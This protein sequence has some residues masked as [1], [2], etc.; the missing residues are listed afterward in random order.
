[1]FAVRK[2]DGNWNE[3][4]SWRVREGWKLGKR[5]KEE[6]GRGKDREARWNTFSSTSFVL[7]RYKGKGGGE[8]EGWEI[9]AF[10][11]CFPNRV[12]EILLA[13]WRLARKFQRFL[14]HPSSTPGFRQIIAE[15]ERNKLGG[16]A[17]R[18][19]I[20]S[21]PSSVPRFSLFYFSREFQLEIILSFFLSF[22]FFFFFFDFSI[23]INTMEIGGAWSMQ[24][25]ISTSHKNFSLVSFSSKIVGC[26]RNCGFEFSQGTRTRIVNHAR[27]FLYGESKMRSSFIRSVCLLCRFVKIAVQRYGYLNLHEAFPFPSEYSVNTSHIYIYIYR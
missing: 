9:K 22:V 16:L 11:S 6:K 23:S 17:G 10:F 2:F 1:M 26:A 3:S 12:N 13:L 25:S 24:T 8:G 21:V 5:R 15:C 27:Y 4:K 7:T 20:E 19:T 14:F 18:L